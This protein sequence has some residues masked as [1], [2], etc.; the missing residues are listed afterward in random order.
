MPMPNEANV[1][2]G[3]P[4][5]PFDLKADVKERIARVAKGEDDIQP[6]DNNIDPE[7]DSLLIDESGEIGDNH[8]ELKEEDASKDALQKIAEFQEEEERKGSGDE[9]KK[10]ESK[11]PGKPKKVQKKEDKAKPQEETKPILNDDSEIEFEMKDGS[12]TQKVKIPLKE[13]KDSFTQRAKLTQKFM[14][15]S[16]MKKELQNILQ[17]PKKL[18]DHFLGQGIDLAQ[19]GKQ[20]EPKEEPLPFDESDLTPVEKYLIENLGQIK[21]TV[22][23]GTE[24]KGDEIVPEDQSKANADFVKYHFDQ[25]S[26]LKEEHGLSD[27]HFAPVMALLREGKEM[28]KGKGSYGM[29]NAVNDYTKFAKMVKLPKDFDFAE[30]LKDNPDQLEKIYELVKA[31]KLKKNK[32]NLSKFPVAS[33]GSQSFK[34]ETGSTVNQRKIRKPKD[35]NEVRRV[36]RETGIVDGD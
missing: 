32:E 16:D 35:L 25:F 8:D 27:E 20:P 5:K 14:E 2:A 17:S 18:Y 31:E 6:T 15:V 12:S 11:E 1:N 23:K 9:E 13:L 29:F 4:G 30:A 28:F 21:K 3:V 19:Y 10:P 34:D 7:D 33:E 36:F 24:K 26:E 22:T